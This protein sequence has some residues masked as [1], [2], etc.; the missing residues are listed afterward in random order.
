MVKWGPEHGHVGTH[1]NRIQPA[2]PLAELVDLNWLSRGAGPPHLSWTRQLCLPPLY[3]WAEQL[4]VQGPCTGRVAS[5][6]APRLTR[7]ARAPSP[8]R[9][10]QGSIPLHD[11]G[12]R[13]IVLP[14]QPVLAPGA[15]QIFTPVVIQTRQAVPPPTFLEYMFSDLTKLGE[16]RHGEET[17]I[18]SHPVLIGPTWKPRPDGQ[19]EKGSSE[20]SL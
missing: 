6:P 12:N 9:P 7:E 2:A 5:D 11:P 10:T 4:L 8:P 18:T 19:E 13:P 14:G 1:P 15:R 20:L 17:E 3:R 16:S